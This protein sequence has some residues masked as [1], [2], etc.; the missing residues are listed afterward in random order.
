[1]RTYQLIL[2]GCSVRYVEALRYSREE[3]GLVFALEDGGAV[4]FKLDE[5]IM[6]EEIPHDVPDG[7]LTS[8]RWGHRHMATPFA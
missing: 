2:R 7:Q 3:S 5:V 1:M 8:D 4:S 6:I